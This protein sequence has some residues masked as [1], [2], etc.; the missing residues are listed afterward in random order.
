MVNDSHDLNSNNFFPFSFICSFSLT[1]ECGMGSG[2]LWIKG[3]YFLWCW[4]SNGTSLWCSILGT[5]SRCWIGGEMDLGSGFWCWVSWVGSSDITGGLVWSSCNWVGVVMWDS[6]W[7]FS[8]AWGTGWSIK[9]S[10]SSMA[11]S[12]S[13]VNTVW[14]VISMA[15]WESSGGG[16]DYW[17][18][19]C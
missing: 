17:N 10:I 13:A 4:V 15:F 18:P 14:A 9:W 5:I 7:L 3:E 19:L 2:D 11:Y 8:S 16:D 12:S 6:S 1:I